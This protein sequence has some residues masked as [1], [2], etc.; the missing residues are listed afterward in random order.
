MNSIGDEAIRNELLIRLKNISLGAGGSGGGVADYGGKGG[1]IRSYTHPT[2][3]FNKLG[4]VLYHTYKKAIKDGRL[5]PTTTYARFKA[6]VNDTSIYRNIS[7]VAPKKSKKSPPKKKKPKIFINPATGQAIK[8][9]SS[10]SSCP[11]SAKKV[12]N[13]KTGRMVK[14]TTPTGLRAYKASHPEMFR[15]QA[16]NRYVCIKSY[17]TRKATP[18]IPYKPSEYLTHGRPENYNTYE[19]PAQEYDDEEPDNEIYTDDPTGTGIKRRKRV[20]TKSLMR[21]IKSRGG[22][23]Y[24]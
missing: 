1:K 21:L 4:P 24:E 5:L 14:T 9:R 3:G 23:V 8:I 11:V 22:S 6:G 20:S 13:P 19:A 10:K 7:K 16:N 12:L 17:K 15:L 18:V 2:G